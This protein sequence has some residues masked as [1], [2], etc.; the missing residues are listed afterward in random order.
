MAVAAS[1]G[2]A[3]PAVTWAADL[4]R[5]S[6]AGL[7]LVAVVVPPD[8]GAEEIS[9]VEGT[10][11]RNEAAQL[12]S[13]ARQLAGPLGSARVVVD[14]DPARAIVELARSESIG[15]LVVGNAGMRGRKELLLGSIANRISHNAS[16]TV[17]IVREDGTPEPSEFEHWGGRIDV[18]EPAPPRYIGRA[19]EIARVMARYGVKRLFA[20][21][22]D[23]DQMREQAR[24]L[25]SALE[26]LGPT[27]SK[28]GQVLST[29]PD[30]LPPVYIQELATLQSDMPPLTEAEVVSVLE[31]ELGVPWEDV[32]MSIDQKPI[33]AGT[34]GQAMRAILADGTRAVL[35]VQRPRA[36]DLIMQDLALLEL[37]A[38][39]TA[40]RPALHRVV[41]VPA[42]FE[43]LSNSLQRELDFRIEASNLVRMRKVLEPFSRLD[44][45]GLHAELS[46]ERLLVMDE[47][48]GVPV[49]QAPEGDDR[50]E[51]ARQLLEAY[52]EQIL[53][54]GFFHA[55]PH[56]G[57]MLWSEGKIHLLDL[58]MVGE[59]GPDLREKL[60]LLL[61]AFANEDPVFLADVVLM[62]TGATPEGLDTAA[63]ESELGQ[64]MARYRHA[65]MRDIQLGPILQ[66]MTEISLRHGVPLPSA[67]TLTG[68]ALAQ[69]QLA[70][71]MLDPTLDPFSLAGDKVTAILRHRLHELASPQ[72]L[73]YEGEK[74][75]IRLNRTALAFERVTGARPGSPL[76]IQ[77]IDQSLERMV[78]SVG[79]L[80]ALGLVGGAALLGASIT[81]AAPGL[82]RWLPLTLAAGGTLIALALVWRLARDRSSRR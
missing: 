40:R 82:P 78:L 17:V 53:V 24:G 41:D 32:F 56:P 61:M 43:E 2:S 21:S 11:A 57:N 18:A 80:V 76:Q 54:D 67:L 3:S 62:L 77:F 46:S 9:S 45:P 72:R 4:A 60:M 20:R 59:L 36:R 73:I 66:G 71:A 1:S 51:A 58:G 12:D 28:L 44:V 13:L 34:I 64:L 25:R 55:D 52:Y 29:R 81:A 6:G 23:P 27:F 33:A 30:L 63:F 70:T 42:A 39:Q 75:R 31:E 65:S 7:I 48:I 49:A 19:A 15:T 47:V 10:L 16:C 8:S 22:D 38:K 14:A 37:F 35:K 50:R 68:K 69:V 79:R 26:E 74:M 5:R